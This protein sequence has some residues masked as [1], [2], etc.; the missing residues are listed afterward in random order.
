MEQSERDRIAADL[1]AEY[2]ST[3]RETAAAERRDRSRGAHSNEIKSIGLAFFLWFSFGTLGAHRFYLGRPLSAACMLVLTIFAGVFSLQ[4]ERMQLGFLLGAA[5][6][7]WWL[8]DAFLIP[9]LLP[10]PPDC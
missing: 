5:L 3:I 9:R 4:P 6:G 7:V 2:R 10:G 8:V 1:A